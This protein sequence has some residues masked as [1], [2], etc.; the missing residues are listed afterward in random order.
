MLDEAEGRATPVP[1]VRL[2]G[3]ATRSEG[4]S[5]AAL[6]AAAESAEPVGAEYGAEHV[7]AKAVSCAVVTER[8][9][10][11][12]ARDGALASARA[13]GPTARDYL[14]PPDWCFD[15]AF[16]GWWG[17][18]TEMCSIADGLVNLWLYQNG[19]P[20]RL[21]GQAQWL[22]INFAYTSADLDTWAHQI[23]VEKYWGTAAGNGA[24]TVSGFST[25]GGECKQDTDTGLR[26]GN[27]ATDVANDG[28]AYNT[29][30][31]SELGEVGLAEGQWEYWLTYAGFPPTNSLYVDLP[32][33]RC[34]NAIGD[35]ENNS[36]DP[37][38]A[39]AAAGAGCVFLG[40]L[41]VMVYSKTGFYPTL[42]THI[43]AAQQSGLPGA[44][45]NGAVLNRITNATDKA[46]NGRTACPAGW[47]RPQGRS[48]D[49]Y[50]FRSTKQGASTQTP[51]GTARTFAPPNTAWCHMDTAWGVP[52][53]VTG[54]TGWSSCMIDATD[55]RNGGAALGAFYSSKRVLD[56]DPYLVWI[57][58]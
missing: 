50:P 19:V 55:N 57:Q 9:T 30:T 54:P 37:A 17:T 32:T 5:P 36:G 18:R 35:N 16:D 44:Y 22:E 34:D 56:G 40:I 4:C 7:G 29:S 2:G 13:A 38:F 24:A 23:R 48:C 14:E 28:E 6:A 12:A 45:P 8:G 20:V 42:A 47:A 11:S 46:S 21:L 3:V 26:P 49:E 33:V 15:H 31:S 51:K 53:G 1:P 43:E 52:T 41:P 58:P 10:P 39:V 27:F 25:C